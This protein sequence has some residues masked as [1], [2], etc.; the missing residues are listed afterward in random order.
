ME[1]MMI[2][3][4]TPH[5]IIIH[6]ERASTTYNVSVQN[7]GTHT[8]LLLTFFCLACHFEPQ[9][10]M[11]QV[12]DFLRESG[13]SKSSKKRLVYLFARK[14]TKIIMLW[15]RTAVYV[16]H[17]STIRLSFS[18]LTHVFTPSP[19]TFSAP[20]VTFIGIVL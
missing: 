6:C 14:P 7:A 13:I 4:F 12:K 16:L 20:R 2:T 10:N 8:R 9:D 11:T 3:S 19:S 17:R 1:I 5:I 18:V 15:V